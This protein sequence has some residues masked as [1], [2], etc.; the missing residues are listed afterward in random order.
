MCIGMYFKGCMAF[1]DMLMVVYN[2]LKS[3]TDFIRAYFNRFL[4]LVTWGQ[5]VEVER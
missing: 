4:L 5:G 3:L 2:T 1:A